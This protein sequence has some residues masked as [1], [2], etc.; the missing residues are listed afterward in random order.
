MRVTGVI[1][2]GYRN[3]WSNRY[4]VFCE[5]QR[6]HITM[7]NIKWISAQNFICCR[8]ILVI[9]QLPTAVAHTEPFSIWCHNC[10]HQS[11]LGKNPHLPLFTCELLLFPTSLHSEHLWRKVYCLLRENISFLAHVFSTCRANYF[12]TR[13][14]FLFSLLVVLYTF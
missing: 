10:F 3:M 9:S 5:G 2:K 14:Y 1:Q 8:H 11:A 4:K 7:S 6:G 12:K 13:W